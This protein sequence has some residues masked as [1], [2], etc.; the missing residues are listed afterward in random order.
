[1]TVHERKKIKHCTIVTDALIYLVVK[2]L[3]HWCV[4]KFTVTILQHDSHF[5]WSSRCLPLPSLI[6]AGKSNMFPSAIDNISWHYSLFSHD[7]TGFPF[8][9][10]SVLPWIAVFRQKWRSNRHIISQSDRPFLQGNVPPPLRIPAGTGTILPRKLVI[11]VV[12][13]NCS[14]LSQAANDTI[15]LKCTERGCSM[16]S[17]G[18]KLFCLGDL[19]RHPSQCH[20]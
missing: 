10:F 5:S 13:L 12:F 2:C 18:Q 3:S 7:Y 1:M 4:H 11:L 17:G 16:V 19:Y 6:H 20:T 9:S 15:L 14:S 8:C